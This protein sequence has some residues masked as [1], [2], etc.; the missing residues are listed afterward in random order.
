MKLPLHAPHTADGR[1]LRLRS[2][3]DHEND[4]DEWLADVCRQAADM[5][6]RQAIFDATQHVQDHPPQS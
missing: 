4:N 1:V 3:A 6:E 5:I 2:I